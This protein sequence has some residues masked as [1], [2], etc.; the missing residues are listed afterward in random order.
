M[1][2]AGWI[3]KVQAAS[4][5]QILADGGQFAGEVHDSTAVAI[6]LSLHGD[7]AIVR[8]DGQR[9]GMDDAVESME[10]SPDGPDGAPAGFGVGLADEFLIVGGEAGVLAQAGGGGLSRGTAGGA[11]AG[12]E[13]GVGGVVASEK[14][15][16]KCLPAGC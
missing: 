7:G 14:V 15:F 9:A 4:E 16:G 12:E 3:R 13:V 8:R 5:F 6:G 1:E 2:G 11:V 10:F